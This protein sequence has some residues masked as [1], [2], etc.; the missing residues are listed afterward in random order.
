[1]VAKQ[2]FARL[3]GNYKKRFPGEAVTAQLALTNLITF[4]KA[5]RDEAG[6]PREIRAQRDQVRTALTAFFASATYASRLLPRR[7]K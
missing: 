2:V 3:D 1:M 7:K 6:H 4:V 5:H